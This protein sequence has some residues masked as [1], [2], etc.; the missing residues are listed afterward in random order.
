MKFILG[1]FRILVDLSAT[2]IILELG[3]FVFNVDIHSR[4]NGLGKDLV[5]GMHL[6]F[7][8]YDEL[9]VIAVCTGCIG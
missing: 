7:G 9:G 6:L 5:G 8:L 2:S 1:I 4:G 3:V